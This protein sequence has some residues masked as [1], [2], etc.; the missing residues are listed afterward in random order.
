MRKVTVAD[1]ASKPGNCG[2][3]LEVYFETEEAERTC[4][5]M[6]ASLVS[7]KE[8]EGNAH[9]IS[10]RR[11]NIKQQQGQESIKLEAIQHTINKKM[12][13]QLNNCFVGR[14]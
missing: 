13:L 10:I 7:D 2:A 4:I 9:E 11:V 14:F 1:E 3:M 8:T 12:S 5:E 6:V